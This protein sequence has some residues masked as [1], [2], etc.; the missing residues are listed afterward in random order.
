MPPFLPSLFPP[1]FLPPSL[2]PSHSHAFTEEPERAELSRAYLSLHTPYLA[3]M[4]GRA[5]PRRSVCRRCPLGTKEREELVGRAEEGPHASFLQNVLKFGLMLSGYHFTATYLG[6]VGHS[7]LTTFQSLMPSDAPCN[8]PA[9]CSSDALGSRSV[10]DASFRYL[11]R[12]L[13]HQVAAAAPGGRR[14]RR[15]R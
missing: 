5:A 3:W 4:C 12:R 6:S 13:D 9:P 8:F 15:R 14:R 11:P 10:V 7:L 2:P 1:S